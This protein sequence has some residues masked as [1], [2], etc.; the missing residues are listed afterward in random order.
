MPPFHPSSLMH[1]HR[2]LSI[3]HLSNLRHPDKNNNSDESTERFQLVNAAFARLK[4]QG[5]DDDLEVSHR[6]SW[7]FWMVQGMAWCQGPCG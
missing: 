5:S 6:L 3:G 7:L 2:H 4:A 1:A